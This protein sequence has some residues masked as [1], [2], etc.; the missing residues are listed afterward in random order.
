MKK[1][2][3]LK[4]KNNDELGIFFLYFISVFREG[5]ESAL[6]LWTAGN[7]MATLSIVGG[8]LGIAAAIILGYLVFSASL[9]INIKHFFTATNIFLAGFALFFLIKG[10]HE[11]L[12]AGTIMIKP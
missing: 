3:A 4:L 1:S 7:N 6:F 8:F 11:L 2:L 9:K 10:V 5:A 12:E